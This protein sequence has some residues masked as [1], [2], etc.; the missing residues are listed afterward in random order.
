MDH[1]YSGVVL[2]KSPFGAFV[3]VRSES[4]TW[5]EGLVKNNNMQGHLELGSE[6]PVPSRILQR[7]MFFYVFVD[8]SF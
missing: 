5:M 3:A 4:N 8:V 7:M 2:R 6:V 1:W